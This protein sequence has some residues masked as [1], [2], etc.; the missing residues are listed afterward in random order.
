MRLKK[1]D[2]ILLS[3]ILPLAI[4]AVFWWFHARPASQ[5]LSEVRAQVTQ[6]RNQVTGLRATF[7]ELARR[8]PNLAAQAAEELRLAKAV[9][10]ST[11]VPASLVELE[12]L[13]Q[14]TNVKLTSLQVGAATA[15]GALQSTTVTMNVE[16]RFFDVDDFL[17]RLHRQV[18]LN[19][20]GRL[21]IKGRLIAANQITMSPGG[22]AGQPA[23][24]STPGATPTPSLTGA[25]GIQATIQAVLFSTATTPS[26]AA[27]AA[28][29]PTAGATSR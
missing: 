22:A 1:R 4:V 20:A 12:R 24:T 7:A 15:A 28:S 21:V 3:A 6:T 10:A 16:G 14:R 11:Q 19:R 8:Q 29:I 2:V 25:A 5:H 18:Q 23:G 27:A 13:A 17:Y 26:P 9:P